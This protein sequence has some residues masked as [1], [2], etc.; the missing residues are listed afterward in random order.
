MKK[1]YSLIKENNEADINIYGDITSWEWQ[2]SDVSSY[3][4]SKEIEGLDVDTINVYINSYGG[5]VAEGLAIYNALKR[6]KAK[7]KTFCDGFAA[8]IASVIFMAGDERI[9]SNASLLFIH[10]A[11]TYAAG[12]A[13]ELRKTADDLETMTQAS[14]NTYMQHVNISEEELKEMLDNETWISPQDALSM[15]FATAIVNDNTSKNPNQ[16][17]KGRVMQQL[18]KPQQETKEHKVLKT[19]DEPVQE[20]T[21]EPQPQQN[22]LKNFLQAIKTC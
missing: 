9:M 10:N 11:W 7:I 18:I 4:L 21:P 12:N 13:N 16:S 15:G 14:I 6:H 19:T 17:I 5:E 8:S 20:P 2:D 3:T 1:Y 22:N